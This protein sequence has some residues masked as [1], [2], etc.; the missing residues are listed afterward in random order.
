M[1]ADRDRA[2]LL[3]YM[4][5]RFQGPAHWR[6]LQFPRIRPLL[7]SEADVEQGRHVPCLIPVTAPHRSGQWPGPDPC[8]DP[9][10][11]CVCVRGWGGSFVF[12][13]LK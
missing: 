3:G 2:G 8:S 6:S 11:G 12:S 10:S 1:C 7:E 9:C 4:T 5:I 13:F